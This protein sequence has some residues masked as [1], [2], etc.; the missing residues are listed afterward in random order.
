MQIP[1]SVA[2]YTGAF[3]P[4]SKQILEG[5]RNQDKVLKQLAGNL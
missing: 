3:L 4:T 5:R 2:S 1:D